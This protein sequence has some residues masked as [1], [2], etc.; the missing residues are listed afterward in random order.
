MLIYPILILFVHLFPIKVVG[1]GGNG[2]SQFNCISRDPENSIPSFLHAISA[3]ADII[4]TSVWIS[5]DDELIISHRNVID[6]GRDDLYASITPGQSSTTPRPS[7]YEHK[8]REK[9]PVKEPWSIARSEKD[10]YYSDQFNRPFNPPL[11]LL[12]LGE[13][14][15]FISQTNT[16]AIL[17]MSGN[18]PRLPHRII[19]ELEQYQAFDKIHAISTFSW[20]QYNPNPSQIDLLEPLRNDTRIKRALR[21]YGGRKYQALRYQFKQISQIH[22]PFTVVVHLITSAIRSI[23]NGVPFF[24]PNND[25]ILDAAQHYNASFIHPSCESLDQNWNHTIQRA[26]NSGIQTM[27]WFGRQTDTF[28]QFEQVVQFNVDEIST[29]DPFGLTQFLRMKG[30]KEKPDRTSRRHFPPN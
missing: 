21:F 16:T 3:G 8:H 9:Y 26:H 4:E 28:H 11:Y 13:F 19:S 14:L 17:E 29:N 15:H 18:D 1:H 2:C 5:K 7:Q 12:T 25:F 24:T 23:S 22:S 10:L 30:L 27:C 20:S 6:S